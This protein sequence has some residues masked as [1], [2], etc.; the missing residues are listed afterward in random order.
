MADKIKLVVLNENTLGYIIPELPN[1]VQHLHASVLRGATGSSPSLV[2]STD[3]IRIAS[4]KDFHEYGVYF[5]GYGNKEEYE[6]A[7]STAPY[8]TWE[9]AM[10]KVIDKRVEANKQY[11]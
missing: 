5:G 9:E 10:A 1:Y 3:K 4:E 11:R 8:P 2:G 6:F 7:D